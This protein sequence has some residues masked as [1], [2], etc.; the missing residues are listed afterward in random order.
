ML[1]TFGETVVLDWGLA[2]P[3]GRPEH[4]KRPDDDG[5]LRPSSADR[6][7]PTRAGF[8]IGTPSYM[9][10]EQARGEVEDLGPASDVF[11]LGATLYCLLTGQAPY[12]GADTNAI[13]DC[14]IRA[15]FQPPRTLRPEIP[16]SL[17]AIC[18]KA[19]ARSPQDRFPSARDLA[20]AIERW[21]A[22]EPV[23]AYRTAVTDYS[24]LVNEHPDE[25]KYREG[26]ARSRVDLA[27]VLQVLGR[28]GEAE[29]Q[30][31]QAID[32]YRS[33]VDINEYILSYREGL[34]GALMR[35]GRLLAT[36]GRDVDAR[37]THRIAFEEYERL[38]IAAPH[39]Q[40]YRLGMAES[41]AL[42]GESSFSDVGV[43]GEP[44]PDQTALIP[45]TDAPGSTSP[46]HVESPRHPID[47]MR[48]D[49][50]IV[51]PDVGSPAEP[52]GPSDGL[53]AG[54]YRIVRPKGAGAWDSS[55]SRSTNASAGRS[56]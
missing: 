19:M 3:V 34:A 6:S 24:R 44:R 23:L 51:L 33:L 45:P 54:R 7:D 38:V 21:L 17:E 29:S 50:K 32:T 52:V 12:A 16:P 20:E 26:L 40:D 28:F 56:C 42:I 25:P 1:G 4:L 48:N 27:G 15:D 22:D 35:L 36:I 9:S 11:G 49:E 30:L 41:I 46:D 13:I 18:L 37:N 39:A 5:T 47:R 55:M 8:A 53:I 14:A 2:K 43:A 10:P 31:Q